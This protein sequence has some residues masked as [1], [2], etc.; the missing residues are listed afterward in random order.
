MRRCLIAFFLFACAVVSASAQDLPIPQQI[1]AIRTPFDS[2]AVAGGE[3]DTSRSFSANGHSLIAYTAFY[4][5]RN[6][7]INM[8][9]YADFSE[10]GKRWPAAAT[11]GLDTVIVSG[12]TDADES[13]RMNTFPDFHRYSRIRV[14]SLA[15]S[16]DT[17]DVIIQIVPHYFGGLRLY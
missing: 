11:V 17:V 5:S 14:N 3:S 15:A 4:R 10:D 16:T 1:T 12:E 9:V 6:D 2:V 13:K 7:S 8:E